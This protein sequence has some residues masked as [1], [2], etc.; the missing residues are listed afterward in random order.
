MAHEGHYLLVHEEFRLWQPG[1]DEEVLAQRLHAARRQ[2]VLLVLPQGPDHAPLAGSLQAL[3]DLG[4]L[5]LIEGRHGA[6]GDV[7]HW[8]GL[9]EE[10]HQVLGQLVGLGLVGD[11]ADRAHKGWQRNLRRRLGGL[12]RRGLDQRGLLCL[13][14]EVTLRVPNRFAVR[15]H[16]LEQRGQLGRHEAVDQGRPEVL[17][18][19]GAKDGRRRR[20]D[21]RYRLEP[22]PELLVLRRGGQRGPVAHAGHV[23]DDAAHGKLPADNLLDARDAVLRDAAVGDA[24]ERAVFVLRE[25]VALRLK[26]LGP[27]VLERV[28]RELTGRH[29]VGLQP[30]LHLTGAEGVGDKGDSPHGFPRAA[31]PSDS[32]QGREVSGLREAEAQAV[33]VPG[34]GRR[35]GGDEELPLPQVRLD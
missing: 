31:G 6:H 13:V 2:E 9:L 25:P 28:Q 34:Q 33:Q 15:L 18:H 19:E 21:D 32:Q 24:H 7:H 1:R 29:R 26:R 22:L 11:D 10:V 17:E 27:A 30:L 35:R 23:Q 4:Q 20:R 3:A 8:P 5:L 16:D 14:D 12:Y